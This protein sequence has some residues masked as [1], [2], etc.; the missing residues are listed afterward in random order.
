MYLQT[1]LEEQKELFEDSEQRLR[2]TLADLQSE[3]VAVQAKLDQ[4]K[5]NNDL[6]AE[7]FSSSATVSTGS[8]LKVFGPC[9]C[10][11]ICDATG[12]TGAN[13]NSHRPVAQ[14]QRQ[15]GLRV[16]FLAFSL[17]FVFRKTSDPG[18]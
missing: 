2:E 8:G 5:E 14:K 7:I 3:L 12:T 11:C 16:L 17:L 10:K 13:S 1:D 15:M 9:K 6:D 18:L 4:S